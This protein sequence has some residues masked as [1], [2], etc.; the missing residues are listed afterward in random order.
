MQPQRLTTR[1]ARCTP[2]PRL[3]RNRL[4]HAG[5]VA[6]AEDIV[7]TPTCAAWR[8]RSGVTDANAFLSKQ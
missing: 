7:Q 3:T 5:L 4:P 2:A 1:P 8:D 6:E